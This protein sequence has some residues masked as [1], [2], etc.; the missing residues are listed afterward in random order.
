[1]SRNARA[2]LAQPLDFFAAEP[3]HPAPDPLAY[4]DPLLSLGLLAIPA[5]LA[6]DS[7]VLTYN[8]ALALQ[9]ALA[10]G[11]LAPERW[12]SHLKLDRELRALALRK[13]AR[14]AADQKQKWKVH[15]R[16]LRARYRHER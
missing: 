2:L 5:A 10:A 9:A 8:L 13:D 6:T 11:T 16:A 14:A 4:S 1:M 15:S 3:C 12:A 7:P